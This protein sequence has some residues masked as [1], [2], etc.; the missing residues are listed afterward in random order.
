MSQSEGGSGL[1]TEESE[2]RE[3]KG[4]TDQDRGIK[5]EKLER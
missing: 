5:R 1:E 3:R 4:L 2:Q